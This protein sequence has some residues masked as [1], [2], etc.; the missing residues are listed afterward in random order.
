MQDYCIL[1]HRAQNVLRAT[2]TVQAVGT[3]MILTAVSHLL[4]APRHYRSIINIHPRILQTV[5]LQR[6]G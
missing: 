3:Q 6:F 4:L 5:A 1:E 2:A